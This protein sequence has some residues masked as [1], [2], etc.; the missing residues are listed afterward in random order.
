MRV[1]YSRVSTTEQNISRQMNE[2]SGFDY[3]FT[4]YCS[5]SIPVYE[6]QKGSHITPFRILTL[7][8]L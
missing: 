2:L 5:G 8:T 4:N 1:F 3:V 7:K 6:R